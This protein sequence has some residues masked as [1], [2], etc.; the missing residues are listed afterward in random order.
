M[1]LTVKKY[2]NWPFFVEVIARQSWPITFG[3]PCILV[4]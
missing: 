2:E 1:N 3:T 4:C